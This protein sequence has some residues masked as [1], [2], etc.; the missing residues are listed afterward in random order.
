M[1]CHL[2]KDYQNIFSQVMWIIYKITLVH[3]T[4]IRYKFVKLNTEV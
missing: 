2:I 3:Q 4:D 1:F